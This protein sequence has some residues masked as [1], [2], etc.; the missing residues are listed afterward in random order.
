M[1]QIKLVLLKSLKETKF[2]D[3]MNVKQ[4]SLYSMFQLFSNDRVARGL[5]IIYSDGLNLLKLIIIYYMD[6]KVGC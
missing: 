4:H 2:I 6:A 5:E 3:Y 1:K